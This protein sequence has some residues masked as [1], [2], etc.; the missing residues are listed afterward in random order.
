MSSDEQT[1]DLQIDVSLGSQF[2]TAMPP[3]LLSDKRS[4][5][6]RVKQMF[7]ELVLIY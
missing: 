1:K 3:A 6:H 2:I 5:N 4:R 7:R